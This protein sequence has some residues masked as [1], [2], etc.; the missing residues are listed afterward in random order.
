MF[1]RNIQSEFS[2]THH[3]TDFV[4]L[5]QFLYSYFSKK[6]NNYY[7]EIAFKIQFGNLQALGVNDI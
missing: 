3:D 5:L 4:P 7:F 1:K 2:A 6:N